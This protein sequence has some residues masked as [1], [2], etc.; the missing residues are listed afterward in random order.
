MVTYP[1]YG[2]PVSAAIPALYQVI[3][4][5]GLVVLART[6]RFGVFRTT[7]LV[8]FLVLPALLQA[9][10][11]GFVAS[12]AMILWGDLHARSA[13][14]ALLGVRRSIWW[15]L[16][17]LAELVLLAL[18]DPRLAQNPAALPTGFRDHVLR[19]ERRGGDPERLRDARLLRGAA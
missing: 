2:H 19:A 12:S 5:A 10:L 11:G 3:T 16:A 17:F 14:L 8:A 4:V 15:L 7:Q 6:R 1:V 18:L 9:S 13:A